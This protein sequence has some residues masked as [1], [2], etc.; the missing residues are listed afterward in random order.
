MNE[1][2]INKFLS[3]QGIVSRREAEKLILEG[4]ILI[5]DQVAKLGQKINS[6]DV[7]KINNQI[8]FHNPIEYKYYL[9]N[10]PKKTICSLKDN[11]QRQTV[12]DLIDDPDYLYPVGRL[13]YDTTGVLLITN[14]GE[15]ANK[16]MHPSY[17]IIRI[18]RAR[19]DSSL[20]FAD[21]KFLNSHRVM[22]DNKQSIQKVEQ[23]DKKTYLVT[24]N[25]GHYHHI[26]KLFALVNKI[27]LDLKRVQFGFLTCEKMMVGEYRQLKSNEI[28]KLKALVKTDF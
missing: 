18:Y 20:N 13:D 8:I 7:I 27:V 14:D 15:M 17:Q 28:K 11:F 1:I 22:V 25:Q 21:L 5:N 23:V 2:R 19:L 4:K 24:I 9:L 6:N 16:L 12:I 3:Q 26:K 10:K